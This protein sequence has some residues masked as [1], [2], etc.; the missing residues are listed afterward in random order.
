METTTNKGPFVAGVG[1]SAGGLESLE[2]FFRA[3][4]ANS[5]VAFVIVQHLSPDHKSLM[6]ELFTRFTRIP[7]REARHG[8]HVQPD[9]IY[10]LPPG[11]EIEI[12]GGCLQVTDRPAERY[13]SFPIDRFFSSLASECASRAVA[14]VLSGSGS[15]GSRGIRRVQAA[16]GLV[17]VEDPEAAAFDGMPRAAIEAGVADAVMSAE[18]LARALVEH[19]TTGEL[20]QGEASQVV[21]EVISLLRHK[22]R[23]D[24]DEYK[25]STVFRRM[26]RRSRLA[27][28]ANLGDY[29]RL[30]ERDSEELSALHRDLLIGVTTF[31]RDAVG[32]DAL[33][34]ELE[35]IAVSPIEPERELRAWVAGCATGEEA[36][37]M[38]ILLD[39]VVRKTG[40]KRSFKVF[41]TDIHDGA[42]EAAGAGVFAADRLKGISPERLEAYFRVR[43]DGKYQINAEIRQRIVFAKH[44]LLT[45]TPFTNLDV[46][47]CRN[48]LIYL[49]PQAQRRALASLCYGLRIGGLLFLGSSETPGEMLSAF[50]TITETG[51]IYRKRVHSRAMHRPEIS[52]R[53]A[54]RGHENERSR[55]ESRLLATYDALLARFMPQGF[56]VND[57]RML[58]DSFNGAESLLRV[59]PRRISSDF[60]DLVPQEVRMPLAGGLAR[61][62]REAGPAMY[63]LIEWPTMEGT[64]RFALTVERFAPRN[65]EPTYLVT[66]VDREAPLPTEPAAEASLSPE[67]LVTLEEELS[68]T[69]RNLQATVEE[70]EASN[71]ELQATNE[72]MVASNEEL[73]SV[74][75]ELHSV[76][77][78]LHTVNAEHQR[79]NAEL[80]EVNRDIRHL[81][82]SIDVAT[83][84][85]DSDLRIRKFT[86]LAGT[87]FSLES[88]DQGRY[89]ASFNHPLVYPT[90]MADVQRVR[91]GEGRVEREV[92]SRDGKWYLVRLLPYRVSEPI[93][94][95]VITLTD[96]TALAAAKARTRQLS[97]IVDSSADAIISHDL[98]GIVTS[99]NAGAERLYGYSAEEMIGRSITV[100]V[101]E[102][103][104]ASVAATLA[105]VAAGANVINVPAVR[106]S[107]AGERLAIAK[108]VSPIRDAAGNVVGIAT[109]DRDVR[110][111][112][113]LE[114]RL[115]ESER[116]YEDLYNK[117]PDMYMSIDARSGRIVEHNET[118]C[119]VTGYATEEVDSMH[120]LDL[121]VPDAQ[122]EA[123][124]C[125][126][127]MRA[128]A[129]INDL[130]LRIR[131]KDGNELDVTLSSSAVF[132]AEGNV[133][134]SRSILRD[135]TERRLAEEKLAEAA[136]MRE[137]FLAMVSHELRS[138]LH[139]MNA[140]L[141]IIDSREADQTQRARSEGVVRRQTRQMV[142]LVDDLLDV[143]RIAHGKL[144]LERAPLDIAEIARAAVEAVAPS[145]HDKGV[146]L[147]TEG[148]E[149]VLP[150]FGDDGRLHQVFTNLLQNALRFTP[151]GK[152]VWVK[153]S[154]AE[155]LADIRV[156]DEGRGID[157]SNI[158]S[159]FEM[160]AQSRQGLAR[161]EGGLGLGL[162]IA[163]RIVT[164]H[165]G[166]IA[167]E[168]VGEGHGATF[169][170]NLPIDVRAVRH[171]GDDASQLDKLCIVVV[172]DQE[173]AREALAMLL[174]LEGHEVYAA[175][176]GE[177]GL[178]L[179]LEHRPQVA[180][181]DI[182]L[183]QMNGYEVAAAVR[184][185]LA[186]AIKLIAMSGYGQPE[187]LKR[188]DEAGFDRHLTKPVD[189][190][191]LAAALRDIRVQDSMMMMDRVQKTGGAAAMEASP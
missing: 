4:P 70:L 108:T 168:S 16:G 104:R 41:A 124:R 107:K 37:S 115:R 186:G 162:T 127:A 74:N 110:A 35:G 147:L 175:S 114:M 94:G 122:D 189:P 85:L 30:L 106:V 118:F 32:F 153:A 91:D 123:R 81:L 3:M 180:L 125:L 58:L 21:E 39:E 59:P 144:V 129:P 171:G 148:L 183:P 22:L 150:A 155:S 43:P 93:E 157:P 78:E 15:D 66:L 84:Y 185:A 187:D 161:T 174:D 111:Q 100:V 31:F 44:N 68:Q 179:I 181:L 40:S 38:A 146:K 75:E 121:F 140:A 12:S 67:R 10:L 176:N 36:C 26:L 61:A 120:A 1:A 55:P 49:R 136:A 71:E 137:Q 89:L 173:D 50:E 6:E 72:E 46:V 29:A 79:K 18:G 80:S 98:E 83:L 23:V 134:R 156:V 7:V 116:K 92:Q 51:K 87:I 167:A 9:H 152:R 5:G 14:V 138:P 165:G 48:L 113:E 17:L 163:E 169:T 188:S 177:Q 103:E 128:G 65:A 191:R 57:Q 69:R 158:D 166:R 20:P 19:A 8:E 34:K 130:L 143:S 45:D 139:A 145:F 86:P 24:F 56:L 164:A 77:E 97:A 101:P 95:V 13:L 159:I 33:A 190:R 25:R 172:E 96:A 109:I 141:Q 90:F 64:R 178:A 154:A 135:V 131:L 27:D 54:L 160:F 133:I 132:D 42:L 117:A 73:Q 119:R 62:M 184:E 105:G 149:T 126:A 102:S 82:E 151:P 182:G 11:K 52:T 170:V 28:L 112:R 99:W 63:S 53:V 60:L 47:S 88:H 76:N 2:R 142:R